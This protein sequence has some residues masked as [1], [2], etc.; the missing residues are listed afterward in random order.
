MRERTHGLE[1]VL[2]ELAADPQ[3]YFGDSSARIDPVTR[4]DRPFSTLLRL[5][6]HAA[7]RESYAFLK[8]FKTRTSADAE[9]EQMRRWVEREFRATDRL[10]RAL[11]GRQGLTAVR[12]LA[13]FP[14]RLA[15]VT[16]EVQGCT[17]DGV[18]RRALWGRGPAGEVEAL[19]ERVGAWVRTYQEVT[20]VEGSLSLV[21]RRE[22]LDVRLRFLTGTVLTPADR[23]GALRLFDA[24]SSR[25]DPARLGLVGIH[26][27]LSPTNILIGA[28]GEV[29]ILDFAMAKTGARYHDVSHLFLHFDRLRWRPHVRRGLAGR[30]QA[31]L[32]RGYDTSLQSSE[33]LFALM[34]LQHAACYVALLAERDAG[35]LRPAYHAL[36]RRRWTHS[37]GTPALAESARAL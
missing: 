13:V 30:M 11:D 16:E 19:A 5:R 2:A 28:G 18:I 14:E 32:L 6:V 35:P 36:L 17:F 12:P 33:P 29:T 8:V 7:G 9:V 27:D 3:R 24:L 26:A 21:E 10:H 1:P 31:A 20:D 22:Y 15:L 34:L 37:I 4:M 25:V 23:D